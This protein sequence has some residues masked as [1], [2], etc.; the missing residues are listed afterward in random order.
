MTIVEGKEGIKQLIGRV[1]K[2]EMNKQIKEML[3]FVK[4]NIKVDEAVME[5]RLKLNCMRIRKEFNRK[6]EYREDRERG[7]V[8]RENE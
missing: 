5:K 6:T 4:S 1:M 3:T 8:S 7:R 2:G